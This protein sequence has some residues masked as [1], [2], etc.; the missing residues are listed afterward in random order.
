MKLLDNI[1]GNKSYQHVY[2]AVAFLM[3]CAIVLFF[4]P[5][6]TGHDMM[7]HVMR[8]DA[9]IDAMRDGA[10][11]TYIDYKAVDGY[12]YGT[13]WFYSDFML[14]PF[15]V[16]GLFTNS[17]FAYKSMLVS[18]TLLCGLLTYISGYKITKN[19]YISFIFT[20]LY[21]FSYYRLYDVYNRSALGETICLTFIPLAIWGAYEIANGNYKKW[22][23]IAI[24]FSMMIYSHINTPVQVAVILGLYFIYHYKSFIKEPIRLGYLG[25]AS[26]VTIVLTSY[27]LL[28]LI[29]QML[30][31]DFYYAMKG[32]R[33]ISFPV[34]AGEPIK[35]I[36]RG[37]FSGATYVV[38]EIA[39]IGIVL[40]FTL[41]SRAFV[42]KDK[43]TKIGDCFLL[44]GLI[45]LFII[46]PLYPWRTFPFSIIGFIQFSWRFY[47]IATAVL[48][49]AG[50]IYLYTALNTDKR[51]YLVGI[52]LIMILTI[53]VMMNSGQV[54][55]NNFG[56]YKGYQASTH[57]SN[58]YGLMGA[59]YMPENIP[60]TKS[61][62]DTRGND[63]I[64]KLNEATIIDNFKRIERVLSFDITEYRNTKLAEYLELPL[65]FYKGYAA[66]IGDKKIEIRQSAN[67]LIEIPIEETGHVIV[68]YKGTWI[69]NTS[70]FISLIAIVLLSIYIIWNSRQERKKNHA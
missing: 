1:S 64:G 46:S 48:S 34:M 31:N 60:N 11:P 9:L 55:S 68:H 45:C 3:L 49:V 39:G 59:E 47:S 44:L 4:Y 12:G 23:V 19:R 17:F 53:I 27:F 7:F 8:L 57:Y 15:A 10:F 29:E 30:S 37:L 38:P 26:I 25:L 6:R 69:Q 35:Y 50:A 52:P 14:I 22:Y 5:F 58:G 67:G 32:S 18:Y 42:S 54:F 20:V 13:K 41:L 63:S 21:T 51:R 65:V 24:A 33:Q 61:F 66:Q 62:F 40:T 36:M 56:E 70:P 43:Y 28:P 2:F 16:I